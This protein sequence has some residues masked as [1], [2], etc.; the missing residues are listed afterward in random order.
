MTP[1]EVIAQTGIMPA[2]FNAVFGT[3]QQA[4][5]TTNR[6]A[7]G[8]AG[9]EMDLDEMKALLPQW[10]SL[11]DE[12]EEMVEVASQFRRAVPPA[13]DEA[14]R[15][16]IEAVYAHADLYQQSVEQQLQ[17]AE[18]YVSSLQTAISGTAG[19]DSASADAVAK[20]GQGS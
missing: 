16:Q 5:E 12:L 19:S 6:V 9:F 8:G 11:R 4:V 17:Y 15:A 1:Q 20:Y 18:G 14:S 10:E 7:A 13:D 2:P 3:V